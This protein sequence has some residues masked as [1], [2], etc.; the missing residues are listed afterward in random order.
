MSISKLTI[1]NVGPFGQIDF[2][3]DPHVNVFLG[4]NNTG[5]STALW[6]LA[7]ITVFPFAF[8]TKVLRRDATATYKITLD[9]PSQREFEGE[10]PVLGSEVPESRSAKNLDD[11]INSY[12]GLLDNVERYIDVLQTIGYSRFIPALRHN[13]DFRSPGP[14]PSFAGEADTEIGRRYAME[15]SR[16]SRLSRQITS[17]NGQTTSE[18]MGHDELRKRARFGEA[19]AS[20]ITDREIM[21]KIFDVDYRSYITDQTYG[22]DIFSKIGQ[23]TAQI[24]DG[25]V[26]GFAGV[27]A[28]DEGFFPKFHTQS[29]VLPLNTMSQGTQSI[30]QWLAHFLVGYSEYYNHPEDY[31]GASGILII[32]EIDAHMHPSWQRRIIPALR[33]NFPD[34]QLF[35]STHSPL[36]V[37]GLQAGQVQLL[38]RHSEGH[39]EAIPNENDIVGWTADEI[40]RAYLGVTDPVDLDTL[41]RLE[42]IRTLRAKI[43]LSPEE[44]DRLDS[45][46]R[47]VGE[48]L[49][50]G[51]G[52]ELVHR[53]AEQLRRARWRRPKPNPP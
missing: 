45:L 16:L 53:F 27:D 20:L 22:R 21:Q 11:A 49:I 47:R 48:D 33:Q 50:S 42:A 51:P 5:K 2:D 19:D 36:V 8:P 38:Q 1:N 9:D 15:E 4:S 44:M 46:T 17:S 41:D 34:I 6:S 24:T 12:R 25:F 28:D 18:I 14:S 30:V 26:T 13:T 40:L 52:S 37:A 10:L 23:V 31:S 35:C 29:G 3:F 39:I 43:N 7:E 32:D